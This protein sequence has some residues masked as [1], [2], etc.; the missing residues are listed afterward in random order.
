MGYNIS[1]EKGIALINAFAEAAA[2]PISDELTYV[3]SGSNEDDSVGYSVWLGQPRF[4]G[5]S[6]VVKVISSCR[7]RRRDSWLT[8]SQVH[9]YSLRRIDDSWRV[10]GRRLTQIVNE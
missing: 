9:E 3:C 10:V 6:A 2:V 5:D 7:Y 8:G 4:E 1:S